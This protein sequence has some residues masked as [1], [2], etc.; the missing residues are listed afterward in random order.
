MRCIDLLV[1]M[2]DRFRPNGRAVARIGGRVQLSTGVE[3]SAP[4]TVLVD[5]RRER[6]LALRGKADAPVARRPCA[7]HGPTGVP[8]S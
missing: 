8:Q 1:R 7:R 6:A 4:S 2:E 3:L 5:A